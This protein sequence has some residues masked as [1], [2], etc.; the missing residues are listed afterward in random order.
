MAVVF[1]IIL[2]TKMHKY[3]TS[4]KAVYLRPTDSFK[5]THLWRKQ[6][7]E[8]SNVDSSAQLLGAACLV[9]TTSFPLLAII[10][11][12]PVTL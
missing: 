9:K 10:N 6:F 1:A 8:A 7:T 2:D 5:Q 4:E 3:L 11:L 12:I